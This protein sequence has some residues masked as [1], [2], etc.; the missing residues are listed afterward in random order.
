MFISMQLFLMQIL[1]KGMSKMG[2]LALLGI[3][4]MNVAFLDLEFTLMLWAL[5]LGAA[6]YGFELIDRVL[7]GD[8]IGSPPACLDEFQGEG[9]DYDHSAHRQ[10]VETGNDKKNGLLGTNNKVKTD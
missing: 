7:P 4:A 2:W 8:M 10:K 5:A 1:T 6:V 9:H 3:Y